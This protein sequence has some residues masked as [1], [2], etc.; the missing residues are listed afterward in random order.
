MRVGCG[1]ATADGHPQLA[2]GSSFSA[3]VPS[4]DPLY[5]FFFFLRNFFSSTDFLFPPKNKLSSQRG[6]QLLPYKASP[7]RTS[8]RTTSP[9]SSPLFALCVRCVVFKE[10][11]GAALSHSLRSLFGLTIA[12]ATYWGVAGVPGGVKM[13]CNKFLQNR[14]KKRNCVFFR[15]PLTRDP[16]LHL[17]WHLS[18]HKKRSRQVGGLGLVWDLD[19]AHV[20]GGHWGGRSQPLEVGPGTR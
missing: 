19:L 15:G 9:L 13:T 18:R 2:A 7:I 14:P 11:E 4:G 6:L 1:H 16:H 5:M 12:P 10:A 8:T 20:Q 17:V 3:L